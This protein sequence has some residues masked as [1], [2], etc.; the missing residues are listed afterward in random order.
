MR[1][2][3]FERLQAL[4]ERLVD[5][6]LHDADPVNWTGAGRRAADLSKEERG[7][8]HWCRK[9]AVGTLTVLTKVQMLIGTTQGAFAAPDAEEHSEEDLDA[10]IAAAEKEASLMLDKMQQEQ[11]KAEF[12]KRANGKT[13]H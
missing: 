3:Q 5:A 13:R 12:S 11:R 8:A 9:I 1:Q 10:E 4:S 2:D 7:D 6:T